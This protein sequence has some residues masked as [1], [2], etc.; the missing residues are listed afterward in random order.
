[1][2]RTFNPDG[3]WVYRLERDSRLAQFEKRLI[4]EW[5]LGTRSWTQNSDAQ[6]K[7]ILEL[8][9]EFQ[10][11]EFPGYLNLHTRLSELRNAYLT[12]QS[13]LSAQRGVYLL[14]FDDGQQYVGSATGENG[15]WQRW[16]DYLLR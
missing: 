6:P 13:A 8:R 11:P 10:E 7:L 5:G 14:V 3:I 4:I 1:M 9:R 12:W 15:F 16:R 2:G